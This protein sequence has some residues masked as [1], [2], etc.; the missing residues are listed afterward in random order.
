MLL[1]FSLPVL[2]HTNIRIIPQFS[3]VMLF[4]L[5]TNLLWVP[6]SLENKDCPV[7]IVHLGASIVLPYLQIF[8]FYKPYV[9][10]SLRY[11]GFYVLSAFI[12]FLSVTRIL[13]LSKPCAY[14]KIHVRFFLYEISQMIPA[15]PMDL[16]SLDSLNTYCS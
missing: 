5:H 16:A 10:L 15:S 7:L 1:I 6:H 8:S 2:L 12:S 11:I 3:L 9:S 4:L 14:I 13:L